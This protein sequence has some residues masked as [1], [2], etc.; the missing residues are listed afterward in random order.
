MWHEVARLDEIAAGG[1]K[2]VRA[3]GHEICLCE[4]EG[5]V[6]AVSRRCGHQNAPLDQGALEGWVLTCPLH[7]AQFDIRS[8]ANLSWPIDHDMG[9]GPQ[10]EPVERWF[11]LEKR[12]D[13]MTRVHDLNTYGVRCHAGSIEV[14]VPATA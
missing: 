13:R 12:L 8:G 1:M 2:D 6:Y 3:G 9:N 11:R 10:P 5:S 4:Y 14:D 7:D